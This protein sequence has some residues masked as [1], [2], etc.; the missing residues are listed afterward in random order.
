[1]KIAISGKGGVGKTTIMALLANE[2]NKAGKD[3]LIIDADPSPH[4]AET[5]GVRNIEKIKP[6]A[7]MT[8]L[9]VER[10]GKVEGSPFYNMNPQVNDLLHDFMISHEGIKLMVLG[11][12]QTGDKGCACPENNVLRRMLTKLLLSPEQVVLLDMEAGVEHLGRGTIA[13]IDQ[14]LIVVIPSRSSI[15][16]ALKIKKLAEDVKIPRID[17]VG[18]LIKDASDR[19]FLS[20]GLGTTPIVFFTDSQA[21]R[22]AERA[23]TPLT[24]IPVPAEDAPHLLMEALS[25]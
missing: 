11:A 19:E 12:I 23:E 17:F 9:L 6:I 3:V 24:H 7:E 2:Y 16:T 14:L 15:R 13:G 25:R 20:E 22:K 10:S 21:I 5:L 8:K 18:N 4:M 1:M